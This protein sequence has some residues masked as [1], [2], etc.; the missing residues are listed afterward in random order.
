M[1][2][3]ELT[4]N[5]ITGCRIITVLLLLDNFEMKWLSLV[6]SMSIRIRYR[7]CECKSTVML[8]NELQRLDQ[9]QH[10]LD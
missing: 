8:C 4:E 5:R 9:Y 7:D 10:S 6:I 2:N 1:K 3:V